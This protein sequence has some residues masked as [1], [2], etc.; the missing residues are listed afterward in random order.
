MKREEVEE[1]CHLEVTKPIHLTS[2]EITNSFQ[3]EKI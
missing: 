1:L 2:I 3:N